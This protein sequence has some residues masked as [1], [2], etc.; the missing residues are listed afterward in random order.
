MPAQERSPPRV[1]ICILN[2]NGWRDTLECLESVRQL[3]YPNYVTMVVDNGSTD[4]S[5]E[6]IKAW[7]EQNLGP[8]HAL[9][10]YPRASALTGGEE[11]IEKALTAFP[12]PP[13]WF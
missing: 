10:D 11:Q 7:A 1:A 3:E 8:V 13:G 12:P 5:A 6:K 9:A 2:W 4:G